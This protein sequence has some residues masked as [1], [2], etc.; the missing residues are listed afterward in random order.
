MDLDVFAD[1]V[2]IGLIVLFIIS[3][4]RRGFVRALFDLVGG[5][6]ALILAISYWQNFAAWLSTILGAKTAAYLKNLAW[7]KPLA[8]LALFILFEVAIQAFAT[9]LNR[10]FH[11]P[12]LRQLN[13]LLGGLL[14]FCQGAVLVLLF[15]AILRTALSAA[16]PFGQAEKW[17]EISRSKIYR[18]VYD[19]NPIYQVFRSKLLSEVGRGVG[20]YEIKR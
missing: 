7:G 12:G 10:F 4:F 6:A 17:R 2:F 3:G 16:V 14:G 20:K 1:L 19:H 9:L 5:I 15:C 18:A 8:I 13:S 11:L